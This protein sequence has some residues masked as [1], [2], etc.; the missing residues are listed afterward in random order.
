MKPA[1]ELRPLDIWYLNDQVVCNF[2]CNY[3][4]TKD[5]RETNQG[6]MWETPESPSRFRKILQWIAR[7]PYR[8]RIRSQTQG[9]P[10]LSKEFLDGVAWLTHQP[11]V[12]FVEFLTNGSLLKGK[13]FSTFSRDADISKVS[14][15]VS[16]HA[17]Q[18]SA[19][20]LTDLAKYAGDV[21]AHVVAHSILFPENEA[22][23][24]EFLNLCRAKGIKSAFT[25]GRNTNGMYP[26]KGAF[27][28]LES[29]PET[30]KQ[31]LNSPWTVMALSDSIQPKGKLCGA[32]NGYIFIRPNGDI[33]P[34]AAYSGQELA[35]M[36]SALDDDFRLTVDPKK[37]APCLSKFCSGCAEDYFHLASFRE[38]VDM[39]QSLTYINP[40]D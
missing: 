5:Y 2:D 28:I 33:Y 27:P 16:Y 34:C 24:L 10:L 29:S 20:E 25:L 22:Q 38:K 39:G 31:F 9:E 32:G 23:M 11:N 15:W 12:E 21:G 35:K 18:I 17:G 13:N 1:Q 37:S 26:K 36:G 14:L 7:Q 8:I 30:V 3:C 4:V 6:K 40:Q 19:E